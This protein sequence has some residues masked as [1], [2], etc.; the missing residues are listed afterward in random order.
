MHC[1]LHP[2]NILVETLKS[3]DNGFGDFFEK[4]RNLYFGSEEKV[5]LVI[6]DCGLVASLDE[7]RRENLRD[8]FRS[9]A[10][11]DVRS[12]QK[13]NFKSKKSRVLLKW[14]LGKIGWRIHDV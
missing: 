2:G 5:R 11:G 3:P 10:K 4:T 6:L 7:K 1:D 14:F 9:V 13:I 12:K 8:V